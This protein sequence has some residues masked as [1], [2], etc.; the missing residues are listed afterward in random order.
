MQGCHTNPAGCT[1]TWSPPRLSTSLPQPRL[2]WDSE[3]RKAMLISVRVLMTLAARD[4]TSSLNRASGQA[5]REEE[6]AE[7]GAQHLSI[8]HPSPLPTPPGT[9]SQ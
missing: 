9:H 7:G 6:E 8:P 5:V 3:G 4:F 2:T 1:G